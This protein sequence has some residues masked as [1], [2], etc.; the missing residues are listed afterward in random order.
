M[1]ASRVPG[2]HTAL[3]ARARP[4]TAREDWSRAEEETATFSVSP[5]TRK[6]RRF[7]HV[8]YHSVVATE[9]DSG[10][11]TFYEKLAGLVLSLPVLA[12]SPPRQASC[13]PG[14]LVVFLHLPS[15]SSVPVWLFELVL[16]LKTAPRTDQITQ[17]SGVLVNITKTPNLVRMPSRQRRRWRRNKSR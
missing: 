17:H 8:N 13:P 6:G 1:T 12:S 11:F 3:R 9:E 7:L 14:L 10:I 4:Q 16:Q 15:S 5:S 2:A